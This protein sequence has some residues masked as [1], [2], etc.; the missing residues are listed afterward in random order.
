MGTLC[1]RIRLGRLFIIAAVV[2]VVVGPSSVASSA[3]V[4]GFSQ[5]QSSTPANTSVSGASGGTASATIHAG[6]GKQIHV[7]SV[8]AFCTNSPTGAPLTVFDGGVKIFTTT[9]NGT[10]QWLTALT[11]AV[12][13][14]IVVT[15]GPCAP[16][17]GLPP[18]SPILNVQADQF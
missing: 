1:T 6:V 13:S 4:T 9:L 18:G 3:V 5:V 7:Y 12:G 17:V 14:T 11:S 10:F 8:N 2:A 16:F 15:Y